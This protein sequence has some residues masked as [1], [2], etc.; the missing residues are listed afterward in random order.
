MH[1]FH[2]QSA[3]R[4]VARATGDHRRAPHWLHQV[5]PGTLRRG[6]D[7]GGREEGQGAIPACSLQ[8]PIPHKARPRCPPRP[9]AVPRAAPACQQPLRQRDGGE[10][11]KGKKKKKGGERIRFPDTVR[12]TS[13][14]R[15]W[16]AN[17]PE[18]SRCSAASPPSPRSRRRR[19]RDRDCHDSRSTGSS[20]SSAHEA[21]IQPQSRARRRGR[22]RGSV[23]EAAYIQV[24]GRKSTQRQ[25]FPGK[26]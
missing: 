17:P 21:V 8:S 20:S 26:S 15:F 5:R 7:R 19:G 12:E 6:R 9:G 10:K 1:T 4:S 24:R 13:P 18:R 2:T 22:R 3:P 23:A 16:I 25:S 14:S 11:K